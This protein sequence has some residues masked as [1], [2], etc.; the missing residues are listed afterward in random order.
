MKITPKE[1]IR[2]AAVIIA[3]SC[4]LATLASAGTINVDCQNNAG[5]VATQG[6]LPAGNY[7]NQLD[8]NDATDPVRS[9]A[10]VVLP[11]TGTANGANGGR[12]R[13]PERD[14]EA[15]IERQRIN[16]G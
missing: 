16:K 4:T 12:L 10:N 1:P 3:A 5:A 7:W 2:L 11:N 8:N 9:D 13:I 6:I 14:V 15:F